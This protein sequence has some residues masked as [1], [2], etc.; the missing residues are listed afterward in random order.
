MIII[1]YICAKGQVLITGGV[2]MEFSSW[3]GPYREVG[4]VTD[5]S[6][7]G[8]RNSCDFPE[9]SHFGLMCIFEKALCL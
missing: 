1:D 9:F 6:H 8:E 3:L 4:H 5:L 2:W 7:Q